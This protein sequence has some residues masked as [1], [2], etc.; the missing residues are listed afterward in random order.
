MSTRLNNYIF[1]ACLWMVCVWVTPVQAQR[2]GNE[3]IR[4]DQQYY[5]IPVTQKGIYRI[6][7][8][9]LQAAG[10]P[11]AA[12]DPRRIQLFH[13]GFEQAIYINGEAN[14]IFDAA[15]YIEFFGQG[16]DGTQDSL[17][18][19]PSSAQPHKYYS[20]Y[21]DTTAYFLTWRLDNGFG[22]RMESFYEANVGNIPAETFHWDEKLLVLTDQY[23]AGQTH[24]R[25]TDLEA[26][27]SHYDY[28][29]GWS[30]EA[31][32]KFQN[33]EYTLPG[34]QNIAAVATKPKLEVL[35]VGR[36]NRNH[37]SELF[38]GNTSTSLRSLATLQFPF[39][40]TKLYKTDLEVADINS[41]QLVVRARSNGFNDA[42]QDYISVS[43]IRLLYPQTWNA[44]GLPQKYFMLPVKAT[45]KSFIEISNPAAGTTL[46]DITDIYAIKRIGTNTEA[47]KLTAIVSGTTINRT[48][49]ANT[50]FLPVTKIIR[51][52]FRNIHAP[53][54]NY[55]IL[56]HKSL[57]Q[58]AGGFTD[59]VRG[60]AGYRAS[61]AGGSYDTL[62]VDVDL[63]YNQFGYG[64]LSPLAFRR[65]ADYMLSFG[66]P[67]HLFIIG[68]SIYPQNVRKD[69]ERYIKDMVP[70]GGYPGS[71]VA[72]TAGLDGTPYVPG[73]PTGRITASTPQHI[74]DYLNK[75]KEQE[76][77]PPN[78]LWR[79]N[80]IHLS[81]GKNQSELRAF[82]FF[83]DDF[84][85]VAEGAY[86]G[87]KV[88]TLSKK[89]DNSVELINIA[90][91]VNKGVSQ[92]TFFGHSGVGITDIEIGWASDDLQG[93]RNKGKYPMLLVN[94]CEAGDIFYGGPSFGEN[95]ILT[96][97]RGAVLFLAHSRVG[98]VSPLKRYSDWFY[99]IAYGDSIYIAKPMGAVQ[100]EV[101][102]KF[103]AASNAEIDLSHAEQ[104][105]LQGD[106]AIHLLGV[107]KP[108]YYTA[109][110]QLFL[111]SFDN[112]VITAATDSFQIGIITSNFGRVSRQ[113]FPVTVRRTTGDGLVE[114][115][116]TLFYP[117]VYYQD[118]LFFT[119]RSQNFGAGGNNRFE[120][121]LDVTDSIP[122]LNENNNTGILEY[123]MPSVGAI[124]L[125]PK[126]YSVVS[127][128]PVQFIAQAITNENRQ[129]VFEL[130]TTHTFTGPGKKSTIVTA[131]NLPS[132][133]TDLFSNSI[134]HDST[135]YYWRIRYAD[136]PD[137]ANNTWAESSFIYI[138]NSPEGWSQSEFPQFSKS[139]PRQVIRN[140]QTTTWDFPE[141]S[142]AIDLKTFGSTNQPEA[143]KKDELLLNNL[144]VIFGGRCGDNTITGVAFSKATTQPYSVLADYICGRDPKVGNYFT[145]VAI[146]N[147]ALVNYIDAVP[148]GDY[149]LLFSSGAV[150]YTSWSADLKSKMQQI[151]A[152]PAKFA[153]LQNGHPYIILGR[154]GAA[155]GTAT[156]ILPD[157]TSG[158]DPTAQALTLQQSLKGRSDNGTIISSLIGPASDWGTLYR[159]VLNSEANSF[160]KW[161]LDI[162][163]TDLQ[164]AQTVVQTNVPTDNFPLDGID[165]KQYPYMR[166]RLQVKDTANLTPPQLKK[167]QVIYSG[168]PEGLI[169]P[170]LVKADTYKIPDKK[171]G[172]TFSV[173]FAF[174]NI[175]PRNFAD[176]LDVQYSFYNTDTRQKTT[177]TFRIAPLAAGDT[178][179]F[180]IPVQTLSSVGNNLLQVYVNPRIQPEQNYANNIYE[181]AYKVQRDNIHPVLDVAFDGVRIMDG[182][183]V[184]P[185]PLIAVSL[186][187][188]NKFLIRKDTVGMELYLKKPC[189]GCNFERISF[190]QPGVRWTGASEENNDFRIE[191]QP[192]KLPDGVY[193]L[194]VQGSDV[195]GN[196]S[197]LEPYRIS[198]EV[199][200]ES[201][202]T[203][204]YPYPNPFSTHTRFVFTLTGSEIPDQIKIQIMTVS[205]K[206]VREITQD[207]LGPIR[208]GNNISSFAWD[209]TDEFGD[210]LANGVYM[211]RVIVKS[212]GQAVES[213]QTAADKAFTKDFGKIYILR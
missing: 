77:T 58:P 199:V 36:N 191:Y 148:D 207:E 132:W 96:P 9:D 177:K 24:Q 140:T 196:I 14:A 117:P 19:I 208:I 198:F 75:V 194:R 112:S 146:Q 120:V 18:Y 22:K 212:N 193:T 101:I 182:D 172:D 156:E 83:V 16:N 29:E 147:G 127:K 164:G 126:E 125:F 8:S 10:F 1:I 176:S 54:H 144:A 123:N 205:G 73:I 203:H 55:I 84:K 11:V 165:A 85:K 135:V 202:I 139:N 145:N 44:G 93:Y 186:K 59:A 171:E 150:N 4:F 185:S 25:G 138:T 57:M 108:D 82:K 190:N 33:K 161:Q 153:L 104:F 116:D 40:D 189:E 91:Q 137:D 180:T 30:G 97:D 158:I 67:E 61:Q 192:N 76:A 184:S 90:D 110:D 124:P 68:K 12:V 15:D 72:I 52:G 79:K 149:I 111:K 107:D 206:V 154:K 7:A 92:I 26:L 162:I 6:T 35:L 151:G 213:R 63:I 71:D 122:E 155:A 28:G 42:N 43:Y 51:V 13:R 69:P 2:F 23:A 48:I 95:W 114:Q 5:K 102:R 200:N 187:D 169:N 159:T 70:T 60:Y 89:T 34:I 141:V 130:D 201:K 37:N 41:G 88:A 115:Y 80:L 94:G 3:W 131:S 103:V 175:S 170:N 17:L 46:Y 106:P 179:R 74:V 87:G 210:K 163:G 183:I 128:Q 66:K 100:K 65:F 174:Q 56:S 99:R 178:A 81:G 64:E 168:V 45:G 157:Y 160:D 204:F 53:S 109:N 197:G 167:W 166:L 47:G 113:E 129:F 133:Q 209:G 31:I 181:V 152:D 32:G 143:Y 21:S 188:E 78:A 211:Y 49:L 105:T 38:A 136:M 62:V 195:S 134:A 27:L 119:I 173:E 86:L 118:T 142:T 20:L 121:I 39:H 98:Y 50:T